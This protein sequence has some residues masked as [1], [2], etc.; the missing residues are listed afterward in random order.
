[1]PHGK[2]SECFHEVFRERDGQLKNC[3]A[4]LCS[5]KLILISE[6]RSRKLF[7]CCGYKKECGFRRLHF[8][9]VKIK[10]KIQILGNCCETKKRGPSSI[11][12]CI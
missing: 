3:S 6:W 7:E 4:V 8:I 11:L 5:L 10:M 2:H 1:M 9:T 12:A